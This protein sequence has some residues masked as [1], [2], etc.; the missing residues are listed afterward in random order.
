MLQ[1]QHTEAPRVNINVIHTNAQSEEEKTN[2][3][4]QTVQGGGV[5]LNSKGVSELVS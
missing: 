3:V 2:T 1:P 5:D 4:V